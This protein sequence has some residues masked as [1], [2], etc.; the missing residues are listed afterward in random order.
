MRLIRP[1]AYLED[2]TPDGRYAIIRIN[3][4]LYLLDTAQRAA[5]LVV[6]NAWAGEFV[7][8]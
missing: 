7:A 5:A 3:Y 6:G 8:E 4:R 1:I 2:Q